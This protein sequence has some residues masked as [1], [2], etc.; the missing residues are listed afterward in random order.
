VKKICLLQLQTLEVGM[1]IS[2]QQ[3]L[4]Y[5]P[6]GGRG[7]EVEG[8]GGS[9]IASDHRGRFDCMMVSCLAVQLW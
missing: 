6:M 3:H 5:L 2:M 4:A 7:M 8:V 1:N 9:V